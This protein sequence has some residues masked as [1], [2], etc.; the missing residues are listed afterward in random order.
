MRWTRIKLLHS[1][2]ATGVVPE[3]SWI[4]LTR[5]VSKVPDFRADLPA[6]RAR[7]PDPE[8]L[9]SSQREPPTLCLSGF[10]ARTAGTGGMRGCD[11]D[12][13]DSRFCSS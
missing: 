5:L 4:A 12:Y 2:V 7:L 10:V 1:A 13:E 11:S 9:E 8:R 3:D 6:T